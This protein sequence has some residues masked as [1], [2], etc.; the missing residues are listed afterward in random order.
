MTSRTERLRRQSLETPPSLTAERAVLVTAFYRAHEGRHSVPVMRAKAFYH[1]CEQK[2]VWIGEDELIVG[3]RGPGPKAVPTFPE[4]TCHSLDDLRILDSR[5][6]TWYRVPEECL[7]AYEAD[8][9]PYWHGRSM[10]D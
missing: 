9:I 6:K 1:L 5:A 10:R 7:R 2:A 3:E 4:L 8:V